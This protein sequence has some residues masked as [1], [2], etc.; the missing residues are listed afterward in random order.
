[1][2]CLSMNHGEPRNSA[3]IVVEVKDCCSVSYDFQVHI[4]REYTN[5][6]IGA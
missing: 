1:M 2:L 6:A 5:A 3:S 4:S